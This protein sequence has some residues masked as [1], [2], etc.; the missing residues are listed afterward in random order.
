LPAEQPD[1]ILLAL[2]QSHPDLACGGTCPA[3]QG[4]SQD[5]S[6]CLPN[7]ILAQAA[8][9]APPTV[10]AVGPKPTPA[11]AI[12]GWLTT[13]TT[14]AATPTSPQRPVPEG[15]MALAGPE[16][17]SL[18]SEPATQRSHDG[19]SPVHV[20]PRPAARGH[21]RS[22]TRDARSGPSSPSNFVRSVLQRTTMY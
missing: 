6:R 1:N 12:T 15:R 7:A 20:S 10:A 14:T 3:G 19:P 21:E 17:P 18:G 22:P 2:V 5:G 11:P 4:L 13:T 16:P 8:K 9:R